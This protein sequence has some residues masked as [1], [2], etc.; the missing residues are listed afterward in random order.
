MT[1]PRFS[2]QSNTNPA[3]IFSRH[4]IARLSVLGETKY[5]D[6]S[7]G[8]VHDSLDAFESAVIKG[9]AYDVTVGYNENTLS[10]DLNGDGR[11]DDLEVQCKVFKI[12]H[13]PADNQLDPTDHSFPF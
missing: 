4:F 13:N 6:P 3:S 7:Y 5:F 9:Y 11:I 12:K 8:C 10:A 1:V 2:G